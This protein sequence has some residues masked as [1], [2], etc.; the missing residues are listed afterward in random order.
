MSKV[1][2]TSNDSP[3]LGIE[4]EF[5]LVDAKT[6]ALSNSIQQV[7]DTLIELSTADVKVRVDPDRYHVLDAP[8][9]FG[10]ATRLREDTGWSPQFSLRDT[11]LDL[12]ND[13]RDKSDK[14]DR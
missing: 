9:I 7:L 6:M 12:L 1:V 10:D 11:L 2:F 14:N 13:W 3:T 4:L 8:L 5:G